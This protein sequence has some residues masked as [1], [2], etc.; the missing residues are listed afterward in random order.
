MAR[1]SCGI[2]TCSCSSPVK[3]HPS[4]ECSKEPSASPH[5]NTVLPRTR[6]PTRRS[7]LRHH[8]MVLTLAVRETLFHQRE[9]D[10]ELQ[11]ENFLLEREQ[12]QQLEESNSTRS[13]VLLE[14]DS[15]KLL[16]WE[17]IILS[18]LLWTMFIAP[19]Y[20]LFEVSVQSLPSG[21]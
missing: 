15:W 18:S 11:L 9:V 17:T 4:K 14:P 12:N 7:P 19:L 21:T 8:S 1:R 10:P 13:H 20:L 5:G 2:P 6:K 3:V 16:M